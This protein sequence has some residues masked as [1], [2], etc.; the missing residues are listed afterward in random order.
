MHIYN[1]WLPPAI[2]KQAA[3][4]EP[5]RFHSLVLALLEAQKQ[6]D[7]KSTLKFVS[8][9]VSFINSLTELETEDVNAVGKAALE[10]L[11]SCPD[12]LFAQVSRKWCCDHCLSLRGCLI[13]Q[14]SRLL[15]KASSIS[16]FYLQTFDLIAG[17]GAS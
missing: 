14:C 1:E 15:S 8:P 16:F 6:G 7:V 2:S 17:T 5:R 12:N 10:L 13:L 4:A 11:T 9:I 3:D